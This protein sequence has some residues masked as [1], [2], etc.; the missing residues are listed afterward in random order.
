MKVYITG[1]S[2]NG[3]TAIVK[4]FNKRGVV[5][6][7]IEE[8]EGLCAWVNR[9]TQK[10][11]DEYFPTMEWLQTHDWICKIDK[12][13]EF[14]GA[15]KD[16][17]VTGITTNQDDFLDLFDKVFLLQSGKETF[18]KR[19][20]TRHLN[21]GENT[22]GKNQVE[23]DYVVSGFLDFEQKLI[24]HGAISINS[25]STISVMADQIILK[26]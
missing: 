19:L 26:T 16:V 22:F 12:L 3:K 13:K 20:E 1:V 8:I 17:I 15:Y 23:R 11:G 24:K 6:F 14:L 18:L 10:S 2:G 4:E 7:D 21:P 5:A 9:E 25:E